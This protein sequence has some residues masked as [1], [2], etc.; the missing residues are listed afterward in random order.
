MALSA[1]EGRVSPEDVSYILLAAFRLLRELRGTQLSPEDWR[2][3]AAYT[4]IVLT[5]RVGRVIDGRR[6]TLNVDGTEFV[7]A[8]RTRKRR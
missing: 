6:W 3:N 1:A 8:V 4:R 7:I 2:T 5:S